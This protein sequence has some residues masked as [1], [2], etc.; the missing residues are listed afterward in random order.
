MEEGK[1]LVWLASTLVGK[2]ICPIAVLIKLIVL[3]STTTLFSLLMYT[4]NEPFSRETPGALAS[5]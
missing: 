2:F 1:L 3:L 5:V 4:E